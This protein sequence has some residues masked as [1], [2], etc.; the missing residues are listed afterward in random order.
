MGRK[1]HEENVGGN[2]PWLNTFADLMNLLLCFFVM[3]FALSD[4]NA[5]KFEKISISMSNSFGVFENDEASI[6][7]E[8]VILGEISHI[9]ELDQYFSIIEGG[10]NNVVRDKEGE[11]GTQDSLNIESTNGSQNTDTSIGTQGS[12]TSTGTMGNAELDIDEAMAEVQEEMAVVS[13]EMYDDISDL[14]GQYNLGDYVALSIDSNYRYVKLTLSGSVLF[15]SGEADMNKDAMPIMNSISK[16]LKKYDDYIIEI[17]GYTDNIPMSNSIYKDNK[18]LSSARALNAAEY[19]IDECGINPDTL[20]Y[21]G[22][23]EY[24]PI[25]SN[26]TAKGRAMNR[27]IEINIYNE[28]SSE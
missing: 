27:R 10:S 5:E 14:T 26:A 28:Y 1:R 16:I 8:G 15:G 13:V 7:S 21:S 20:K 6:I 9:S 19:L 24:E 23:G 18:W 11:V 12:D 25:S 17:I 2:A 22:R 4:I 3:L